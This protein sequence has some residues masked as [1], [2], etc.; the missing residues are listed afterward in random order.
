MYH[1]LSIFSAKVVVRF[2]L[3]VGMCVLGSSPVL[4]DQDCENAAAQVLSD[5]RTACHEETGIPD[6]PSY[7][8]GIRGCIPVL[9]DCY[10]AC[11][12]AHWAAV[13]GCQHAEEADYDYEEKEAI[14]WNCDYGKNCGF[15]P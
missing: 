14:D 8:S 15:R 4:A 11:E 6:D 2:F 5:C 12:E 7:D 1:K 13:Q 9:D 3:A 10:D